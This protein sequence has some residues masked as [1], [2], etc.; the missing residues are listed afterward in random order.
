MD[1]FLYNGLR[2]ERVKRSSP[3]PMVFKIV[4]LKNLANFTAGLQLYKKETPTQMFPCEICEIFKKTFF[5]RTPPV[6]SSG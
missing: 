4:V 3:L 6:I 1:W 2:H 5:Y